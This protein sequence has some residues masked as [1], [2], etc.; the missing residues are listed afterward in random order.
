M[1][2]FN[3][4]IGLYLDFCRGEKRLSEHT[5]RAYKCDL[6]HFSKWMQY[7]CV[8]EC[9]ADEIRSYVAAL[10]RQYAPATV[11]R[12]LA[13]LKAFFAYLADA[14]LIDANPFISLKICIRIPRKL[15]RTIPMGDL[16]KLFMF[17][18]C[19]TTGMSKKRDQTL[20]ELLIATGLRVFEACALNI[21]DC[22]LHTKRL[23]VHGKGA[24]E[25]VIQLESNAALKALKTYL[26]ARAIFLSLKH[27]STDALFINRFGKR[28]ST[29]AVREIVAVRAKE[30]GAA[31]HITPH[32]FRHTFATLLLE[33]GVDIRFIQNIL[34][35]SS[36]KTTEIYTHVAAAAQR[37]VLREHNPRLAI[38]G[39]A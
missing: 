7:S 31:T 37:N 34:G 11:K 12:K 4:A 16:Q 6:L 21:T 23:L 13:S 30:V 39:G 20:F 24:K 17:D 25:R 33:E 36:I 9:K 35:H 19:E 2:T 1:T 28:L 5:L 10:N 15:P 27:V 29:Q 18:S 14:Q 32:M 38:N 22:D 26:H 8:A 3:Q